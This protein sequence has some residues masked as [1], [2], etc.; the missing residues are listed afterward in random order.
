MEKKTNPQIIDYEE[1]FNDNNKKV[2]NKKTGNTSTLLIY[3]FL[4]LLGFAAIISTIIINGNTSENSKS[5]ISINHL[6]ETN[7]INTIL[8]MKKESYDAAAKTINTNQLKTFEID[9]DIIL[10][11]IN[12]GKILIITK[13]NN[14]DNLKLFDKDERKTTLEKILNGEEIKFENND[15][16]VTVKIIFHALSRDNLTILLNT[17][18]HTHANYEGILSDNSSYALLL[19]VTYLLVFIPIFL[20]NREVI[21]EDYFYL[22]EKHKPVYSKVLADGFVFIGFSIVLGL[23]SNLLSSSLKL[24]ST[25][26][27]QE[28]I[29][30]IMKSSGAIYAII[31]VVILAPLVEELVFRK[32]IFSFFKNK[33]T[34]ICVSALTFGFIH[35]LSELLTIFSN[36][37]F[38]TIANLAVQSISYLGAGFFLAYWYEK[39]NRNITLLILMHSSSNLFSVL[40]TLL[41]V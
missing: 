34:A 29:V 17:L 25:S 14:E 7:D 26:E 16:K 39:N 11:K 10:D 30:K 24:P 5:K 12:Y 32:S 13:N 15:E 4:F 21:K 6:L 31:S 19:F 22:K 20:I 1:M 36:F 41:N 23:I 35:I 27:N 3:V 9:E 18:S 2:D 37:N 33:K 8:L 28:L 40:L 38:N